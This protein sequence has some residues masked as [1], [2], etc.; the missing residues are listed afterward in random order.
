[1]GIEILDGKGV[2]VDRTG[3]DRDH[4]MDIRNG[5]F[6]F[7]QI[8]EEANTLNAKAD[9]LYKTCCHLF[10]YPKWLLRR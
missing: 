10:S 4:L 8:L 6:T 7:D 3:I 9:E 1:M 2:N 5:A